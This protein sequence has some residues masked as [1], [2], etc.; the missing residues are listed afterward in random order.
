[1]PRKVLFHISQPATKFGVYLFR[2]RIRVHEDEP[3]FLAGYLTAGWVKIESR[4]PQPKQIRVTIEGHPNSDTHR[5]NLVWAAPVDDQ[6]VRVLRYVNFNFLAFRVFMV[7]MKY[8]Y[9]Q[10]VST[11][12][13]RHDLVGIAARHVFPVQANDRLSRLR[14][15]LLETLVCIVS[16]E[17]KLR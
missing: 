2:C 10:S 14:F 11:H 12:Y 6:S 1:M 13:L 5:I 4:R 8:G 7:F 3:N 17:Q 9:A 15:S 16:K